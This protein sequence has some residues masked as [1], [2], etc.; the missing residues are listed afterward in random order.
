MQKKR[1]FHFIHAGIQIIE[2]RGCSVE[3][4][5]PTLMKNPG[6]SPVLISGKKNQMVTD[7]GISPV[8]FT[9]SEKKKI[10]S[11]IRTRG[12]FRVPHPVSGIWG[13]THLRSFRQPVTSGHFDRMGNPWF[14]FG[15]PLTLL[16]ELVVTSGITFAAILS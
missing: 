1:I 6:K 9:G 7:G 12:F 8:V 4:P 10:I 11:G 2:T 13:A 14:L 3:N 16:R 15:S 5:H